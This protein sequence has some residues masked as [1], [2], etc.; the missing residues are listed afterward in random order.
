MRISMS[1]RGNKGPLSIW[2]KQNLR[3]RFYDQPKFMYTI[4]QF[5][6]SPNAHKLITCTQYLAARVPTHSY[7]MLTHARSVPLTRSSAL[8]LA[9]QASFSTCVRRKFPSALPRQ[10]RRIDASESCL[11]FLKAQGI[12]DVHG[13]GGVAFFL[14]PVVSREYYQY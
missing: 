2:L 9:S 4:L 7:R 8:S 12:T 6:K 3:P 5:S 13:G 11:D 14:C 1:R 10:H